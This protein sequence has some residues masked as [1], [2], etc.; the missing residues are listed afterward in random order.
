MHKDRL[1]QSVRF[2]SKG[3]HT[4]SNRNHLLTNGNFLFLEEERIQ[5]RKR[6]L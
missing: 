5:F 6:S 1:C 3:L 4:T 2:G